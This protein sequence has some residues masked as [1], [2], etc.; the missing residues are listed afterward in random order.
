ML[1]CLEINGEVVILFEGFEDGTY[2]DWD[3]V[4]P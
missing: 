3:T 4:V 1:Y 2:G